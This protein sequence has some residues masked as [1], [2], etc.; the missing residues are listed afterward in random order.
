ME[1]DVAFDKEPQ[2]APEQPLPE[3]DQV[4]P[5]FAGSFV[6]VAVKLCVWPVVTL[7]EAGETATVIE[8]F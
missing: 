3:R 8:A 5:L 7:A 4:T 1:V 6:T 2:A